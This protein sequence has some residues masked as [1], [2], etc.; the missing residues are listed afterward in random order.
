MGRRVDASERQRGVFLSFFLEVPRKGRGEVLA[1]YHHNTSFVVVTSFFISMRDSPNR[2]RGYVGFKYFVNKK[3]SGFQD[4]TQIVFR[5]Q[6]PQ[7]VSPIRQER[8]GEVI[9]A[10]LLNDV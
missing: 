7:E 6:I 8:R 1:L 2:K 3:S 10:L 5:S 4:S 9:L